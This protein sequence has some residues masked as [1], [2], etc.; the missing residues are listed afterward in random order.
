[1]PENKSDKMPD[2]ASDKMPNQSIKRYVCSELTKP[3]PIYSHATIYNGIAHISAVQGFIPETFIFPEG[4]VAA[5]ANQ[6]MQ[7][8]GKILQGIGS[9]F[10]RILKMTLFFTDMNRDFP[11]VN[12][13]VN[14]YIPEH[15]PARSSI[16]IAALPRA[17]QVVVD[18]TVVVEQAPLNQGEPRS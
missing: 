18:C 4:G 15:S 2:Q 6:M 14:R 7:N 17:A 3:L 1:M 5:E 9:D 10:D 12:E 13:V 8:L 16:G 11:A